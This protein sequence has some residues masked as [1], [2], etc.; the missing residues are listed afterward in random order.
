TPSW[1]ASGRHLLFQ[2][3]EGGRTALNVVS[4]DGGPPRRIVTPQD[5]SDPD[6]SSPGS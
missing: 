2:R 4:I 3:S 5:G 1:S 6:W